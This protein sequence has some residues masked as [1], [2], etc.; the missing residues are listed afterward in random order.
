MTSSSS[1]QV[2]LKSRFIGIYL[3]TSIMR[4]ET[5]E[6]LFLHSRSLAQQSSVQVREAVAQTVGI[7]AC[8]YSQCYLKSTEVDQSLQEFD[9]FVCAECN[10]GKSHSKTSILSKEEGSSNEIIKPALLVLWQPLLSK[11]SLEE[12]SERVQVSSKLPYQVVIMLQTLPFFDLVE[13]MCCSV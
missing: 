13:L 11:L 10:K 5:Y 12:V 1:Y 3:S 2:M 7:M 6:F 9:G 8:I 4:K